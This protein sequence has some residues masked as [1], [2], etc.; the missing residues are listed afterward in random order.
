MCV[1]MNL[2]RNHLAIAIVQ[3]VSCLSTL[4]TFNIS[5][6]ARLHSLGLR[7]GERALTTFLSCSPAGPL[8]PSLIALLRLCSSCS[9]SPEFLHPKWVLLCE[10]FH[11]VPPKLNHL[12]PVLAAAGL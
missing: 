9:H 3:V 5:L 7:F 2:K 4:S 8:V 12:P 6:V 10:S 11:I 1:L